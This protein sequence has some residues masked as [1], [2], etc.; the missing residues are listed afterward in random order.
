MSLKA[1]KAEKAMERLN[2]TDETE[3]TQSR[4]QMKRVIHARVRPIPASAA[5]V[6]VRHRTLPWRC[7]CA[8]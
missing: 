8:G 3:L 5:H 2:K 1:V 6:S 7:G 4:L